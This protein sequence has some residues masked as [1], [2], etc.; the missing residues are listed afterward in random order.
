MRFSHI[1]RAGCRLASRGSRWSLVTSLRWLL[2]ALL[3]TLI[4]LAVLVQLGRFAFPQLTQIEP[5]L[6][7]SLSQWLDTDVRWQSMRTEW[8]GLSPRLFLEQVE[9]RRPGDAA[10]L[11]I[12]KLKVELHLLSLVYNWR[13]ALRQ[14]ELSGVSIQLRQTA[15]GGWD[16]AGLP[17]FEQSG[18]RD[19]S[20]DDPW[21]IFL[22]GRRLS[23]T[24]LRL[25]I[26]LNNGHRMQIF[27]PQAQLANDDRF[28]RLTAK[29][30]LDDQRDAFSLV[31]EA[32][33]DP[34]DSAHFQASGYVQLERFPLA[35]ALAALGVKTLAE[36]G[37]HRLSMQLWL[38]RIADQPWRWQGQVSA[39]GLP[40]PTQPGTA[41]PQ[42]TTSRFA[43]HYK[44]GGDWLLALDQLALQP[45]AA[46]VASAATSAVAPAAA[47]PSTPPV[48]LNVTGGW[49]APV[50]LRF[51]QLDIGAWRQ[52]LAPLRLPEAVAS[53]V[54]SLSPA[55]RLVGGEIELTDK[56]AG[57]FKATAQL[58]AG[59]VE[60]W[61]G[62]PAL[63]GV[64]GF[65]RAS[66][67]EGRI[68]VDAQ[69]GFSMYYPLVYH[70]PMLFDSATGEVAWFL[71][72]EE[73]K[74]YVTSGLLNLAGPQGQGAGYL[75][76]DLPFRS[77][78]TQ[79]PEM[80]LLVGMAEGASHYH[81]HYVPKL[82]P[83]D[84]QTWLAKSIQGGEL[85]DGAFIYRGSLLNKALRPR[86]LQLG[87]DIDEAQVAF[88]P[89]W[90]VLTEAKADLLIDDLA[91]R[92]R[93]DAGQ[94]HGNRLN[95]VDIRLDMPQGQPVLAIAGSAQGRAEDALGLLLNSPLKAHLGESLAALSLRGDYAGQVALRVPL[96]A[97]APAGEQ[98]VTA[99]IRDAVLS[100]PD[101]RLDLESLSGQLRY[102]HQQGLN[103]DNLRASLWGQPLQ[104][105]LQTQAGTHGHPSVMALDFEGQLDAAALVRWLEQPFLQGLAGVTAVAGQLRLPLGQDPIQL[106]VTSDL[107]GV[108][109]PLPPPLAKTPDAARPFTLEVTV[110]KQAPVLVRANLPAM[111]L[112]AQVQAG[113]FAGM[114]LAL[115]QGEASPVLPPIVANQLQIQAHLGDT[116]LEP[117][118]AWL[119][120][121]GL[122]TPVTGPKPPFTVSLSLSA[123]PARYQGQSFGSLALEVRE[124]ADSWWFGLKGADVEAQYRRFLDKRPGQLHIARLALPWSEVAPRPEL[125]TEP[126]TTKAPTPFLAPAPSAQ[127]RPRSLKPSRIADLALEQIG[128]LDVRLDALLYAGEPLG[129]LA[130]E[131]RPQ[132]QGLVAQNIRG[133]LRGLSTQKATLALYQRGPADWET[134]WSGEVRAQDMS[135]V[136]KQFGLSPMLATQSAVFDMSLNWPGYP[137]QIDLQALSGELALELVNG[138]FVTAESGGDTA[139]LKLFSLLNFDTLLRRLNFDFSDLH[140]EGL[141]FDKVTGYL[142][143]DRDTVVLP[144]SRPLILTG[145]S[146][147]LSL[148]GELN[149]AQQ[150]LEAELDATL[151]LTGNLAVAA[152]FVAG[153]PAAFGVYVVGKLFK[154]QVDSL[155]SLG[156][157]L[158]GPWDKPR[159]Q[160]NRITDLG[161]PFGQPQP[162]TQ[163][164]RPR[165]PRLPS[166]K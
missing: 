14:L 40:W 4:A 158:S 65:V 102:H 155:A 123:K 63:T 83:T 84:L 160:V 93:L 151:P 126:V 112:G 97:K 47:S 43:G 145:T 75:Y 92:I 73:K 44:P 49:Q 22:Y 156:Y 28:H 23:L 25:G 15:A 162:A 128:P 137:D 19:L 68:Q 120:S 64:T 104:G 107:R 60:P 13:Q 147:Q 116:E 2:G 11:A 119:K 7:R 55:G 27:L 8:Q 141:T 9:L 62:A 35:R 61:Q 125:F 91:L 122:L 121:Q 67:F 134:S 76:L 80:T 32:L 109:V 81:T 88:D 1:F 98:A 103:L 157:R 5:D 86:S 21:D 87:M 39:T 70:K 24:D 45:L 163:S 110:P 149:V 100:L 36:A 148:F 142:Q 101:L 33:G 74:V 165:R 20:L 135:H 54:Q 133:Q 34:R 77:S 42:L 66:A 117:W 159:F 71:R 99:D 108:T 144:P 152:A 46:P 29:I 16:V 131:F 138:R 59:A 72:L 57:Y 124:E 140:P 85:A 115:G 136:L 132:P 56:T 17:P 129:Q 113:Q 12:A 51:D 150:T 79:E 111:A 127:T 94:L 105:R 78:A 37:D 31:L 58:E 154:K 139:I 143:F 30:H 48:R 3:T 89:A 114:T 38:D 130:F 106:K 146:A 18:R 90:P 95:D 69:Q 50:R 118:L 161:R 53:L 52:A 41:S 10:P 26:A 166:D 82:I 164:P 6:Q 96:S 153:L